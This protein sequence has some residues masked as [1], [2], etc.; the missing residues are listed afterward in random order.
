MDS[1]RFS[2][3]FI[4][5]LIIIFLAFQLSSFGQNNSETK[6]NHK[7]KQEKNFQNKIDHFFLQASIQKGSKKSIE[8]LEQI[9]FWT[10]SLKWY[11][12]EAKALH[13]VGLEWKNRGEYSDA[14]K[15]LNQ[16]EALYHRLNKLT[17]SNLV[18]NDIAD[19]YR[20]LGQF[21]KAISILNETS[22]YF[23]NLENLKM[24][25]YIRSRYAANYLEMLYNDTQYL[26]IFADSASSKNEFLIKMDTFPLLKQFYQKINYYL[27]QSNYIA[28]SQ[29]DTAIIISNLII[30]GQLEIVCFNNEV[31]INLFDQAI[32]LMK[33][34]GIDED[35]PL[36]LINKARV[37]GIFRLNKPQLAVDIAEEAL[38][39][40]TKKQI[41]M[42]IYMASNVLHENY[43]SLKNYQKAYL[44]LKNSNNIFNTFRDENLIL[45]LSSSDFEMKIEKSEKEIQIKKFQQKLLIILIISLTIIFSIFIILLIHHNQRQRKLLKDLKEKSSIIFNQNNDLQLLIA[46]KDRLF[47]II[48]HDL[49]TPFNIILGFGELISE[50]YNQLTKEEIQMYSKHIVQSSQKTLSLLENLLIWAKLQ[51]NRIVFDPKELALKNIAHEVS[52]VFNES[53]IKKNIQFEIDI[54]EVC[55]VFADEE[56]LK[57]IFRNLIS[58]AIKF[59]NS[60]GK[61]SISSQMKNE[62][63]LVSIHDTGIG[64]NPLIMEKL[65]QFDASVINKGT[66]NEKGSGI[67]LIICRELI[68]KHGG[69]IKV[70]SEPD[71]GSHFSFLIPNI[72]TIMK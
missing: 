24:A 54:P 56:M 35:L 21:K 63:V 7:Y 6:M 13:L 46:E 62:G 53:L 70:D 67:G 36:A 47:S 50:E 10:D 68:E 38:Q 60:C 29:C 48:G 18:K 19:T 15:R 59:T 17:N 37:F 32:S 31:G 66:E 5:Y 33:R 41:R 49:R 34:S 71:Q 51:Q 39:I 64:I 12:L 72:S 28:T 2:S 45:K 61:I 14:L 9:I 65:F 22:F 40:S 55:H 3:G 52:L 69:Y 58:N 57:T 27:S 23:Q 43:L 8:Y 1:N 26:E 16:A 42:Y 25:A 11:D 20:C 44:Y 4:F 30:A